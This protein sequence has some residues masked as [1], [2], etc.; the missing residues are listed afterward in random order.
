[1]SILGLGADLIKIRRIEEV[2]YRFGD[3]FAN[4][5]L[6]NLELEKYL[7]D[8][9]PI[10]FLAKSFAIKEAAAKAFGTGIGSGITFKDFEVFK[11][12]YGKPYLRCWQKAA[13]ILNNIGVIRLHLTLTDEKDYVYALV[14]IEN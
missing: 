14:L 4:R 5:I 12:K 7:L 13:L 8:R 9:Y 6:C 1:M 2:V 3:K 11:D 10:R